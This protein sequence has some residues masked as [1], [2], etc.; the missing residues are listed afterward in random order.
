MKNYTKIYIFWK[1]VVDVL[2]TFNAD[3]SLTFYL[4]EQKQP[5]SVMS[6]FYKRQGNSKF[7]IFS[8]DQRNS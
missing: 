3:Y 1:I 4:V 8:T 5:D 2:Y 6:Y 7:L